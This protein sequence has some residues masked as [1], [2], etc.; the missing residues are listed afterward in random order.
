MERRRFLQLM[1]ATPVI[2]SL[3]LQPLLAQPVDAGQAL[4]LRASE[5]LTGRRGLDIGINERLWTLLCRQDEAFP[6]RLVRLM[7]RLNSQRS[8]DRE[9]IIARLDEEDVQTALTI[10]SPW[11][12]GYTGHPSTTKAA[13]DAQFVT[14]IS[15]LMYEP[16]RDQTVRPS[17]ARAGRDYWAEAPAGVTAPAMPEQI[18]EWGER[19]P[20][21]V[22][23]IRQPEAPWL[24]MAQGKAKTFA[25]A[26]V[27]LAQRGKAGGKL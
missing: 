10:I 23:A 20:A 14:F 9:Q 13:D 12:L 22:G 3:P 11:Y 8:E 1:A 21:A 6:T 7:Q 15:A 18:R 4:L 25:E 19:S 17:Y 24:L 16:T 26:S 5:L 2:V 27:I